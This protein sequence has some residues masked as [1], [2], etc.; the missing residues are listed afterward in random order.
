MLELFNIVLEHNM[1]VKLQYG[2]AFGSETTEVY[3]IFFIAGHLT[4]G[5]CRPTL[6][7]VY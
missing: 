7:V 4:A 5:H 2:K 1:D 6:I 3:R